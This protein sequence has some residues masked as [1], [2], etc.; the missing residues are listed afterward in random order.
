MQAFIQKIA[1]ATFPAEELWNSDSNFMAIKKESTGEVYVT[2]GNYRT[3][4]DVSF[5]TKSYRP[6]SPENFVDEYLKLYPDYVCF[7]M[8]L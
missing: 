2:H 4:Y 6:E 3:D 7:A 8:L 5:A 1:N